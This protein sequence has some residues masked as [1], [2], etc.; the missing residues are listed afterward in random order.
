MANVQR[1]RRPKKKKAAAK[2]TAAS[3]GTP[4]RKK[5][6]KKP[7]PTPAGGKGFLGKS[8][9]QMVIYGPPGVGKTDVASRFPKV[10]F[11]IDPQEEG[12]RILSEYGQCPAPVF[13]EEASDF[14]TLLEL[15]EDVAAGSYDIETIVFDSLTGMEK[16]CFHYHCREYFEDDWTAKGFY[17]YQQGP[18]NAAKVDWPRF[19]DALDAIRRAG[20]NVILLAHSTVKTY[21]NPE[22]P[23]YDRFIPYLDKET[24]QQTHR[25]AKAVLFYN[26][27]VDVDK[28]GPR[29]K[30]KMETEERFIYAEWSPAYDAKNQYG[31]PALIETGGSGQ[32]AFE[33]FRDAMK[34]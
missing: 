10:G 14:E 28:K 1:Q 31:L 6:T 23:D 19:L 24:W 15:A 27:H 5:T 22:G 8:A 18:K 30:A 16:L 17:S 4:R 2:P 26:Y 34:G 32:E 21:S 12:I 29:N 9:L 33:N 3:S 20:I 11:I 25:W 13:V 7:K